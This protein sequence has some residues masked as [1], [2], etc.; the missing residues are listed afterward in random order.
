M[1]KTWLIPTMLLVLS[2]CASPAQKACSKLAT[3]CNEEPSEATQCTKDIEELDKKLGGDTVSKNFASCT[4]TATTCVEATGC[5]VGAGAS[6]LGKASDQLL[7][8]IQNGLTK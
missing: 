2:A 7:K 8:G 5:A 4:D 3:L 6:A 1:N